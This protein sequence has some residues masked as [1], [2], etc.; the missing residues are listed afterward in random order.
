MDL[1]VVYWTVAWIN[2]LVL[3]FFALSGVQQVRR[4]QVARHRRS[5][6]TAVW[7]VVLFVVSYVVKLALLGR[8]DLTVWSTTAIWT[9]RIHELCVAI[10]LIAGGIALVRGNRIAKTSLLS[11]APDAPAL[12]PD[13]RLKHRR[14]GRA[15]VLAMVLA[16]L[17]AGCVLLGMY[18]RLG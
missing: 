15:A 13:Q 17:S 10:M 9:L 14:A 11:D 16:L 6:L 7:L 18:A 2:L 8:E 3:S 4:G 12:D 5:M 1:K